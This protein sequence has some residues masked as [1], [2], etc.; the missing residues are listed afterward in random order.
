MHEKAHIFFTL[1]NESYKIEAEEKLALI[2][3]SAVPHLKGSESK[4]IINAYEKASKDL[5]ES[6]EDVV[7]YD[8]IGKIKSA[9]RT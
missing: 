3:I 8:N 1:L 6:T 2:T 5:L 9:F 4:R 7:D